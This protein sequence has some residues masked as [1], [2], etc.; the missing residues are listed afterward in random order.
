MSRIGK[1]PIVVPSGVTVT[2]TDGVVVVAGPKGTLKRVLHPVVTVEQ[3]DGQLAIG[4]K[5]PEDKKQRAL[6]GL[7][8]RLVEAMVIGVTDGFSKKLEIN[9]VGYKAAVQG[10]TLVLQ[11]GFSHPVEYPILEGIAI[12]VEKNTVTVSGADKQSVGQTAA[13]IRA[14][15]KPEPYKGKG[16]KYADEIIRRKAG[17]SAAKGQ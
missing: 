17:K 16:I 15:K 6:W 10:S 9:G 7:S 14:I 2:I 1:Q 13:E 5:N 8:Q 11:V 12:V 4:V 3:T